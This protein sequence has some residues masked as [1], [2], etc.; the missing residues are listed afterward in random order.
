MSETRQLENAYVIDVG[1]RKEQPIALVKMNNEY[2]IGFG[3]EIK[4]N[5]IDWQYG[6]YYLTDFEKAK[7]DFKRVL[8]GENL[9]DTFSEKEEDKIMEDYQFYSVEEVMKILKDK[10]KLLYVDDGCDE[11]VIKFEDLPDVI[12]DINTK[13]GMTDLKIYDYQNP[14]MTPLATTMGIFLDKCK[15]DLREKIIDRL[16]KLQQGEIEVKDYKMIDEYILEEAREKL[17]QEKK[18]KAKRNKEAR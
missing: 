6:Y 10:E 14:S 8:A 1:Y 15:P 12:V 5:K 16:V 7:T 18:T 4:D 2:V 11:V 3:Y 9:D 17:E 13:S